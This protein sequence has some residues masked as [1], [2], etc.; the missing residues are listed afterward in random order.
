MT[1]FYLLFTLYESCD[2]T[3]SLGQ[4]IEHVNNPEEFLG[5][6]C[7]AV[8]PNGSLFI[9]TINRTLKSY[10]V[11]IVAAERLVGMLPNGA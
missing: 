7:A 8:A 11:A 2:N 9:S 3:P 1:T 4:V 10:L 6:C 5:N